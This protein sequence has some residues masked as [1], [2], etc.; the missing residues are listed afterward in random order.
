MTFPQ[1]TSWHPTCVPGSDGSRWWSAHPR[2]TRWSCTDIS[3]RRVVW[4]SHHSHLDSPSSEK[5]YYKVFWTGYGNNDHL[6]ILEL[7]DDEGLDCVAGL[8]DAPVDHAGGVPGISIK[9]NSRVWKNFLN[10]LTAWMHWLRL[11]QQLLS[12]RKMCKICKGFYLTQHISFWITFK[13][14]SRT[15]RHDNA[16]HFDIWYFL[17][18]KY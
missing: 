2:P 9:T 6:P 11:W 1:L 3:G 17:P 10:K 5:G 8:G 12:A 15:H 18:V 4:D 7:L 14:P 13:N 16:P